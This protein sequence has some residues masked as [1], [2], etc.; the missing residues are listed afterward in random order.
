MYIGNSILSFIFHP[1]HPLDALVRD[2]EVLV[3]PSARVAKDTVARNHRANR[4][5]VACV[6]HRVHG[7]R[8]V[9]VLV[10]RRAVWADFRAVGAAVRRLEDF[11]LR[12]RRNVRACQYHRVVLTFPLLERGLRDSHIRQDGV[13]G[14]RIADV[15]VL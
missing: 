6:L 9:A 3:R 7:R 13:R 5:A 4:F 8:G 10:A 1:S 2:R 12:S 15:H 14:D 11:D